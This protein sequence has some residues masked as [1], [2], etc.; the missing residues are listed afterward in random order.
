[1]YLSLQAFIYLHVNVI[2]AANGNNICGE[3][4]TNLQETN[5]RNRSDLL[6]N[7]QKSQI[8]FISILRCY[9]ILEHHKCFFFFTYSRP[10]S[11]TSALTHENIFSCP[12]LHYSS[13]CAR[14]LVWCLLRN[15]SATI[16]QLIVLIRFFMHSSSE[17]E[18]F[19]IY[20]TFCGVICS[21]HLFRW[22]LTLLT[23][24]NICLGKRQILSTVCV[25]CL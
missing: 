7:A 12:I 18:H 25:Y 17:S 20:T 14:L 21:S 19:V 1:M 8:F 22:H 11:P 10:N 23:S 16:P 9:L 6:I 13:V 4:N 24:F 3:R 5:N 2:C 15:M